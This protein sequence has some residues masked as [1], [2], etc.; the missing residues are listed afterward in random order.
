M[1]AERR[2]PGRQGHRERERERAGEREKRPDSPGG[3]GIT[4]VMATAINPRPGHYPESLAGRV[5]GVHVSGVAHEI[6]TY[7]HF[8][9]PHAL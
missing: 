8:L 5:S 3:K 6:G 2:A 7:L 9:S 4:V 1:G